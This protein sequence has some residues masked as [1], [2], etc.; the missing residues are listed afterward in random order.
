M[1][2]P[3]YRYKIFEQDEWTCQ[4]CGLPVDREAEVPSPLAPT[5]DHIIP[6]A[7]GGTHEP[8][9]AQCAHFICN[10]TKCD[11]VNYISTTS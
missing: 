4:L 5:I 10:S 7:K 11:R 6:L 1:V 2:E 3:V 9:N 8:S